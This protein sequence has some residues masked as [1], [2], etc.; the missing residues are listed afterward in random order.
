MIGV[1]QGTF[2]PWCSGAKQPDQS[3]WP[4]ISALEALLELD[5]G[6][7]LDLIT[8]GGRACGALAAICSPNCCGGGPCSLA[9]RDQPADAG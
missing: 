6:T 4:N 3:A 1:V 7:L 8:P 5:G 9:Q 2:N